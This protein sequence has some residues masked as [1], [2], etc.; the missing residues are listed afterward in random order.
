MT[1]DQTSTMES[2]AGT[3]QAPSSPPAAASPPTYSQPPVERPPNLDPSVKVVEE[4]FEGQAL[5]VLLEGNS[6]PAVTSV[7]ARQYAYNHRMRHGM[8]TAGLDVSGQVSYPI[9]A[10]HPEQ[11][12]P[13]NLPPGQNI[14]LAFRCEYRMV[15]P[16]M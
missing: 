1:S 11:P 5:K 6:M 7:T 14:R 10:D 3:Q 2:M 12:L 15:A 16:V 8:A 4:K 13:A 9:N